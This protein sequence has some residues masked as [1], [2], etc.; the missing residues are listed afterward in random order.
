[1]QVRGLGGDDVLYGGSAK[2]RLVGGAGNDMLYG[3]DNADVLSGGGG[4]DTLDGGSGADTLDGGWGADELHGGAGNDILDGG[5][6]RAALTGGIGADTF[7]LNTAPGEY[8]STPQLYITDFEQ[9]IDKIDLSGMGLTFLGTGSY[10]AT[11]AAEVRYAGGSYDRLVIDF[12]GNGTAD[13]R[14]Q[15]YSGVEILADDLIL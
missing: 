1:M 15:L 2:D 10:T 13:Y 8:G 4:A 11:G 12:D 5:A 3:G 7:V 14:I 6:G 9:G